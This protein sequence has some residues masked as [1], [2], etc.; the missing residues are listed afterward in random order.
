MSDF[1]VHESSY[2]DQ[3]CEIGEGTKIWHFSHVMNNSKIGKGCIIGQNVLIS[4]D[5]EVGDNCKI[6]NNVSLYTGVVLEDDVFCGP[7]CVF[8]NVINPRSQIV[9]RSEYQPTLV[10][11]G[12]TIG[13]NSTIVCGATLGR[14]CF[15]GA[16]AVVRGDVADY[17]LM[18]GVPARQRGWMGRHGFRLENVGPDKFRCPESGWTYSLCDGNLRCDELDED[19]PL[20]APSSVQEI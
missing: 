2:V 4:P 20:P 8:T 12:A 3:P 9:R 5:V 16:G 7:S 17:A 1:F 10:K 15:I 6:Q 19:K 13:A 18:L 14:Y 11:R